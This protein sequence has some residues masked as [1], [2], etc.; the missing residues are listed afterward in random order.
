[1][2]A[3]LV[4]AAIG[5]T[6]IRS[7]TSLLYAT[8]GEII[9]ERSGMMNL[10][11]E[12][13]LLS[14]ALI[15]FAVAY[16]TGSLTLAVFSAILMGVLLAL[17]FGLLTIYFQADQTVTG[18]SLF[19]FSSGLASFLGQR[20]GP[21]NKTLVGL[22]GPRFSRLAVPLLSG[23]P[24]IGNIFFNQDILT[25]ILYLLIPLVSFFIYRTRVGLNIRSVGENPKTADAL[26]IRV[27]R[28]RLLSL[29]VGGAFVSLGGAHISLSYT[30]GWT[31]NITGGRGWI[32]IALVIFSAWD[33]FR[34]AVGTLLFGG[35]S[36][37]QF[38]LQ[39]WGIGVPSAYLQMIPYLFTLVILVLINSR[40]LSKKRVGPPDALGTNYT[41][42]TD[43]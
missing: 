32:V 39:A 34:A 38:Q 1:M 16:N 25:Y 40:I 42:E 18:L 17:I 7:G 35:I 22:V 6:A 29:V 10:G 11:I 5:A 15:A 4:I 36:A 13:M 26:G 9:S 37:L 8:L 41:R 3:M 20:L 21:G 2:E 27:K 19:I 43:R 24:I 12:G 33:P 30:P 28:L 23:I 14:S 31:E